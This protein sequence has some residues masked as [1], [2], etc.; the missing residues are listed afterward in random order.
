VLPEDSELLLEELGGLAPGEVDGVC[1]LRGDLEGLVSG[2][3][4]PD[5][6]VWFL[7]GVG[8]T[9]GVLDAVVPAPVGGLVLGPHRLADLDGLLELPDAGHGLRE[10]VA[11][12]VVLHH[13]PPGSD[14]EV[15]AAAADVVEA[16]GDV[17]EEPR[18]PV[19]LGGH[20]GPQPQGGGV[21]GEGGEGRV[22]LEA[23]GPD[24]L[25]GEEEVVRDPEGLEAKALSLQ[26]DLLDVVVGEPELGLDLDA[27]VYTSNTIHILYCFLESN[28]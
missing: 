27:E 7:D 6:D 1:V 16:R 26:R 21:P 12:G 2:A 9:E 20:H 22:A 25:L 10:R 18:V 24:I 11:V 17:R 14:P 13:L 5:G 19:A 3:A 23:A 8:V 4:D 28:N 15:E